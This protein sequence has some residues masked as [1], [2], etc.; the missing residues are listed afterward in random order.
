[1]Q[2]KQHMI[3]NC[4]TPERNEQAQI[5]TASKESPYNNIR[6]L[7]EMFS[8]QLNVLKVAQISTPSFFSFY[9]LYL[10]IEGVGGYMLL[11][12]CSTSLLIAAV[13]TRT[14]VHV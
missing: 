4:R 5:D 10:Y 13:G 6:L 8:T 2:P 3:S 11:F 9:Q 12:I 1:M 7:K 14:M